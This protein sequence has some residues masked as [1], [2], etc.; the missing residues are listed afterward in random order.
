MKAFCAII[1]IL[2]GLFVLASI[3]FSCIKEEMPKPRGLYCAFYI[4]IQLLNQTGF[5]IGWFTYV[6][7]EK[8]SFPYKQPYKNTD[9]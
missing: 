7:I 4:K 5:Y 8:H 3:I 1:L 6:K 2:N 9:V